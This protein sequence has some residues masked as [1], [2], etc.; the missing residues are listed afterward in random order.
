MA[1]I[2]NNRIA[3]DH[4]QTVGEGDQLPTDLP[5]IVSLQVWQTRHNELL[6][7]GA[8]LGVR[9]ESDESAESLAEDLPKLDLVAINFPGFGDGRGFSTARILR[10]RYGFSG[11]IRAAGYVI[12]DQVTF[13]KRCGFDAFEFSDQASIAPWEKIEREINVLY[14][15]TGDNKPTATQLRHPRTAAAAE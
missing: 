2:K 6:A 3:E 4:W 9:L 5:I 15:P 13:L 14:Q 10:E 11:E 8:P 7:R 12:R 1:L